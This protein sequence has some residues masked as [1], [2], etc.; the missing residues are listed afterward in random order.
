MKKKN[1]IF[2]VG[3]NGFPYGTARIE[4]LKMIGKSLNTVNNDVLF[5]CNS[6]GSSKSEQIKKNGV[7]EGMSY[8]Y[9]GGTIVRPKYFFNRRI[10]KFKGNFNEISYLLTHKCDALI[11]SVISGMFLPIFKYWIISRIK[12]Y[13]VYYPHHEEEE[14]SLKNK[15]IIFRLNLYL[16]KRYAYK[17]LDGV[18]PIS[19]YLERQI[20]NSNNKIRILRLPPMTDFEFFEKV[21]QKYHS[22]SNNKY[23]LYCGSMAYYDVIEFII[24]SFELL[25][26][27]EY[28]LILISS[29]C[30]IKAKKLEHRIN[31]STKSN[32]IRF[33]KYLDY[34]DLAIKYIEACALLIPLRNNVQ[35]IARFPHKISEYTASKT[36]L[37]STNLGEMQVFF[38]HFEN[39]L[40]ADQYDPNEFA[41]LM[42]F[43]INNP[44]KAKE[45]GLNGF[46]IGKEHFD[47]KSYGDKLTHF[48]SLK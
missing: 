10:A 14:V 38:K 33:Y 35:D 11:I 13:K 25:N 45:I 19:M 32:L 28:K 30:E 20:F 34:E 2:I 24:N 23:F 7:H 48:M 1:K 6:W 8:M 9:T 18:F 27:Q 26:N 40:L 46:E 16:F 17:L 37:I 36:P 31:I 42:K 21:R 44:T 4:K 15:N 41:G 47:Y 3:V 12:G 29:G 39:A 22:K 43:V 5:L